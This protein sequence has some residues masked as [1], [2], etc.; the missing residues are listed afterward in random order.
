M[1]RVPR[2]LAVATGLKLL[3]T[4]LNRTSLLLR[5][6]LTTLQLHLTES[7]YKVVLRKSIPA[8]SRHLIIH[9]S[10]DKGQLVGFVGE[11]TLQDAF[12]T[13]SMR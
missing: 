7:D 2:S 4:G 3:V 13:L 1:L 11:L 5:V 6:N 8:Q 10:R 12:K 9:I